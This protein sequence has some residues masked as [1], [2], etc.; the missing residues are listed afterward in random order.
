MKKKSIKKKIVIFF[1]SILLTY[2]YLLKKFLLKKYINNFFN[3]IDISIILPIYNSEAFLPLCLNSIISQTLKNIEIICIDDGSTDNSLEIINQ[4][5]KK[6]NRLIIIHQTNQGPGIARNIGINMSKGKFIAFIDS[7]DIYP[8]NFTLELMF[9]KA[10]HNKVLI[11]G[12]GMKTFNQYNKTIKL[13][14]QTNIF[15]P[16]DSIINYSNYQYDF[17]Y[18]RFIYNKNFIKK[19]KLYFPNYLRYQDPPFFIK[20]MYLAKQFYALKDITYL[21][22]ASN[23]IVLIDERRVIVFFRGIKD[24]LFFS[25]SNHLY[26]LYYKELYHFNEESTII[27]IKKFLDSKNLKDIIAQ[28]INSIDYDLLRKENYTFIKNQIY[29]KFK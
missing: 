10:I 3:I 20:T 6:D 23:K 28:I 12:G 18:Q 29:I 8:N 4:Y 9:N 1:I 17:Y 5:K 25:K 27:K 26:N 16:K 22:R 24:C 21:Y 14:K 2:I 11:C 13:L 19:N 15:F 7:D